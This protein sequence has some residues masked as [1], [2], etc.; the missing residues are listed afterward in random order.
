MA[1]KI[2]PNRFRLG[3]KFLWWSIS[4]LNLQNKGYRKIG[5]EL[6]HNDL[7]IRK[8]IENVNKS[9]NIL[10]SDIVISRKPLLKN[11]LNINKRSNI[12][13]QLI[14]NNK[15][16]N[17]KYINYC[18]LYFNNNNN[19]NINFNNFNNINSNSYI[20]NEHIEIS[21]LI[22]LCDNN[23]ASNNLL[24]NLDNNKFKQIKQNIENNLYLD[25]L[26]KINFY[27][28][29]NIFKYSQIIF[30]KKISINNVN[31]LVYYLLNEILNNINHINYNIKLNIKEA[32]KI[33]SNN[34]LLANYISL[35]LYQK[36][37]QHKSILLKTLR[38]L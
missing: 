3:S 28:L 22:K 25:L 7:L 31:L 17:K 27:Q 33:T 19:T 13:D 15:K 1:K 9:F 34:K 38:N 10:T 6:L 20:N 18:N 32:P 14:K 16:S 4:Y 8:Y 35:E 23:V 26:R 21:Y 24:L 37:N 11:N 2:N 36:P 12:F 30:I 5:R 29:K